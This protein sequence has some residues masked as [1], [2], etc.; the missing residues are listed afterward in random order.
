MQD[1][2]AQATI[3]MLT[4]LN[5]PAFL[6]DLNLGALSMCRAANLNLEGGNSDAAAANYS[7][8]AMMASGLFGDYHEGYRLGKMA[9]DLLE[10][11]PLIHFGARTYYNFAVVVPW[12]QPLRE[13]IDPARRAFRIAKERGDPAFAAYACH[14]LSSI[15]LALGHPLDQVEREVEHG[16]VFVRRFGFLLD[17][18]SASFALVRTLRGA[19]EQFGCLDDGQF[20]E[21]SFEERAMGQPTDAF[22]QRYYWIRKLQARFFAGDYVSAIDAA[23]KLDTLYARTASLSV[24]MLDKEEYHFYAALSRA[25]GCEPSDPDSYPKHREALERHEQALRAWAA[26]CPQ[27]FEDRAALVGAEVARIEGRPLDAMELYERAIASARA[28]GFVHNEALAYETAAR[29]YA[30]RGFQE[31]ARLYLRNARHGYLRWGADG[32]VRQLDQLHPRLMRDERAP[33][34]TGTIETPVEH[35][36]LATVIKVSQAV[37]SEIVLENLIDTL[38]RMAMEQAGAERALLIMPYGQKPRI[39]A[40]ATT[41]G[42]TVTVCLVDEAVNE[43]ALPLSVLHYVLRTRE[44]VVLEDAAAQS[45]YGVDSYIRQRQARSILCLPLLNQAKLIGVL[46]FEN[47]LA[48]R[49]F[50]PARMSVL[51]LLAS[52]AAIAL[53]NANLYREAAEREKQ[54]IATSEMLRIIANTPIQSVLDAV[55]E[56]AARLSDANNAE[57]FR[58]ENNL[59]RLSASYGEIPVVINAYQGVLVNRDTVTGRAACDRR[60]THVHDLAAEEGEYPVGSSNA[61]REGHR[62]TLAVPL[63]REGMAI[64]IILVRRKELRPFSDEQIALVETFADQAVIAIENARLFE[65]E[66]QRTLALAHANRDLAEREAKIRR[67]VDSNVIGIFI[68]DFEGRFLEAND[69]FL[70][71]VGYERDDLLAGSIRWTDLTPPDWRDRSNTRIEQQKSSGRFEPFEK[72]YSRKDG[73]RVPVLIGGATFEQGGNEGVAFV[74]DLTDRKRAENALRESEAKLRDYAETASD[75]FWEIDMDY[76]FTLLT[77]NAFGSRSADRIGTQCW[78]HALDLETEPEKWRL[79]WA[80]LDARESFRDFVYCT[81]DGSGAP[82]YVKVSGKPIFD[83]SG[84]FLGYR[85]TGTDVTAIMRGQ[86]AEASLQTVQAELAHVSRVMTLGQLTA[87]I[88]HEVNQPIGSARNNARAALNFLDRS[89]ADLGE[90]REALGCIVADADRA[91]GI[92]DRI[93][94]QIKK[95]PPRSDPFD[96]NRALEE[97]IGLAQSMITEN[98]VSVQSRLASGMAP[99]HGDRVQLQQVVLNLILNAIEAMSSVEADERQLFITTDQSEANGTLVAVRDSGPG[100][101]PKHLEHVFEAFYS[102]KSGLGMGL[103]ICRSIIAAHGG[104]L[105]AAATEPRGALFQFTL[106]SAKSSVA[107]PFTTLESRKKTSL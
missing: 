56:N 33:G 84:K 86:R 51:K 20:T 66:K 54:Q 4:S 21:R 107:R 13:A 75:W 61:R 96:L 15:F 59:L 94:D 79:V 106:P 32:K 44:I 98:G 18:I 5:V 38:M 19:T 14:T 90:V 101:D 50:G 2:E 68:W 7:S 97:V 81:V 60:T 40:E 70:R 92:I 58:L 52:Q 1:S 36:D 93:R 46:Y 64:G 10:R 105:W 69:E 53:E 91:G 76:K 31:I 23:D 49:I 9:C 100:I 8:L 95:V 43:R 82:M 47:N 88:A 34:P 22:L 16:M 57:I 41:S 11:R 103:S 72:E 87:S 24:L 102:T 74:V 77:E 63:L 67:L 6:A 28:N 78:D 39:E 48:S 37:S 12:T 65:A 80:T 99:V 104:R 45:P 3:D 26:N 42:D 85:G 30:A 55:A 29:F 62:T 25:A 17:R 27:N 71:I 89:P 35:L 73:S 83:G